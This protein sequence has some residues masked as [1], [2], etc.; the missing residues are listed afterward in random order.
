MPEVIKKGKESVNQFSSAAK[1]AEKSF[2]NLTDSVVKGGQQFERM[3]DSINGLGDSL[4]FLGDGLESLGAA[5][6]FLKPVGDLFGDLTGAAGELVKTVGALSDVYYQGLGAADALSSGQ[7]MLYKG[8]FDLGTA[9]GHTFEEAQNFG[10]GVLEVATNVS[11]VD[12]GYLNSTE[13]VQTAENL[14]RNR[15]QMTRFGDTIETSAGKMDLLTAATLQAGSSGL[16]TTQYFSRLSDAI[17]K[18]GL[19][20]QDAMEQLSGFKDVAEETGLT[21]SSVADALSGVS[22]GF[23]KLGLSADFGTPLLSGFART[24]D[25]MGL[26]IENS[27]GLTTNL[28]NALAKLSQDYSTVYVT[29]QRGGLNEMLQGGSVLGAGINLQA[30]MLE[31][32]GN[33]EAQ[34]EIGRDLAGALRD[35]IASFAGGQI[36]TVQEAAENPALEATFYTQSKLLEQMYGLDSQTSARTLDLL[37]RMNTA[38]QEGN[39]ELANSLAED[40]NETIR[41]RDETLDLQEKANSLLGG[42]LSQTMISNEALLFMSRNMLGEG[43][44]SIVRE[45]A[46][47]AFQKLNEALSDSNRNA[48]DVMSEMGK[49]AGLPAL[50]DWFRKTYDDADTGKSRMG[51]EDD[52]FKD[53]V[54]Q[55]IDKMDTLIGSIRSVWQDD[56]TQR[57]Q[58][59]P[60]TPADAGG[61]SQRA[62]GN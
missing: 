29:A 6:F 52:P 4:N 40:L 17:L 48:A 3:K 25:E 43:G 39:T 26:G 14:A 24:M 58:G 18:Q 55:L 15:V 50:N 21:V 60:R 59:R 11:D 31:A 36:V 44:L 56:S 32:E 57:A 5:T 27:I 47:A 42:L 33:P 37:E 30:R 7:R 23:T 35:T 61:V 38:T 10:R 22:Q 19:E 1:S 62:Q 12:F 28:G 41:Q 46:A 54:S 34:A 8:M 51:G 2:L 16:E 45:D 53:K 9:F 13:L 49:G 20:T